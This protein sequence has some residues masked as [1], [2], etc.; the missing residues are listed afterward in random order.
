[1]SGTWATNWSAW[2]TNLNGDNNS[3]VFLY[4]PTSG[5]YF[6]ALSVPVGF[7][8]GSGTWAPGLQPVVKQ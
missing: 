7:A 2:V 5:A 8:Y 3:D 4:N 6:Q 1:L